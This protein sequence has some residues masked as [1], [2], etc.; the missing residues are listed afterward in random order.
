VTAQV[1]DACG[2]GGR[3]VTAPA[4]TS[5]PPQSRLPV[6]MLR[7][8]RRR[9]ADRRPSVGERH[10]L[11][12]HHHQQQQQR[13]RRG[14]EESLVSLGERVEMLVRYLIA[15]RSLFVELPD[16]FCASESLSAGHYDICWNG[17]A[18]ASSVIQSTSL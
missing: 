2:T 15:S 14:Q 3:D 5:S 12:H 13:R 18:L 9:D 8:A 6:A 17:T 7:R 10:P 1:R 11:R 16:R 4:P